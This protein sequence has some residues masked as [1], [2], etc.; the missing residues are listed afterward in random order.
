LGEAV[1][2]LPTELFESHPEVPWDKMIAVRNL[3]AHEYFRIDPQILW[4]IV[5]RN[6]PEVKP[7]LQALLEEEDI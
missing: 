7:K 2:A 6:L 4:Q 3:L 5:T 1:N